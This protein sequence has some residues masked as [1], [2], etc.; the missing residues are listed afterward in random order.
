[1][2]KNNSTA[3][4]TGARARRALAFVVALLALV[5]AFS[6]PAS[7]AS[8]VP[9]IA[10]LED[11][12]IYVGTWVGQVDAT[13]PV[14]VT[15]VP[16]AVPLPEFTA[17][18]GNKRG[19]LTFWMLFRDYGDFSPYALFGRFE[20]GELIP[21]YPVRNLSKVCT[22]DMGGDDYELYAFSVTFDEWSS[23]I[24]EGYPPDLFNFYAVGAGEGS[25]TIAWPM[26]ISFGV[27][28]TSDF[29]DACGSSILAAIQDEAHFNGYND[30]YFKGKDYGYAD[31]YQEGKSDGFAEGEDFGYAEGYENGKEIGFDQGYKQCVTDNP[32]V[33]GGIVGGMFDGMWRSFSSA[34][35]T[36]STMDLG[37]GLTIGGV[38][39]TLILAGVVILILKLVK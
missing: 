25:I 21:T 14:Q 27:S 28:F 32:S 18:T 8:S 33:Q 20:Y 9:C 17:D 19:G 26:G 13:S 2:K 36:L 31:G 7:A 38:V 37:I 34:W 5:C 29:I 3:T 30:G 11:N 16:P 23:I 4:K 39:G 1:M 10:E 22:F 6:I 15:D 24:Y 35:E 12:S